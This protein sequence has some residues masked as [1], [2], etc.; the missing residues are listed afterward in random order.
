[1]KKLSVKKC[2]KLY[3]VTIMGTKAKSL[4]FKG[5]KNLLYLSIYN[6]NIG[7]VVYPKVKKADWRY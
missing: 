6:S 7:K 2:P 4:D 1:M 3:A 5:N